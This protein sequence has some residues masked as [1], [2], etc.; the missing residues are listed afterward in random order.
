[1]WKRE[2]ETKTKTRPE[3]PNS[4]SPLPPSLPPPQEKFKNTL[5]EREDAFFRDLYQNPN[6]RKGHPL[7]HM[8]VSAA[9]LREHENS[10]SAYKKQ[11][12]SQFG[13]AEE[14]P[15]GGDQMVGEEEDQLASTA[16]TEGMPSF[17]SQSAHFQDLS[18][19]V[20]GG[21]G[22]GQKRM[23]PQARRAMRDA[24][25]AG[26]PSPYMR[27]QR[28]PPKR[29]EGGGSVAPRRL[30]PMSQTQAAKTK[31]RRKKKKNRGHISLSKSAS[32]PLV[33][34][35]TDSAKAHR[36]FLLKT[37]KDVR[38]QLE[39]PEP[40]PGAGE[41]GGAV[42]GAAAAA[43]GGAGGG[44]IRMGRRIPGIGA[45]AV[46][47]RYTPEGMYSFTVTDESSNRTYTT[48]VEV[49]VDEHF[50]GDYEGAARQLGKSLRLGDDGELEI[51]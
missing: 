27:V 23:T 24:M 9:E 42:S 30:T 40:L 14:M 26:A 35:A 29:G 51:M 50:Q 18:A 3:I 11:L 2:R 36:E 15:M 22:S 5:Q 44:H 6:L 21:Q 38:N 7:H 25:R 49:P 41:G 28:L 45:A 33:G 13:A 10:M 4:T 43:A 20:T 48:D 31:K 8:V 12:K 34:D 16:G 47:V 46:D 37:L 19:P 39:S 32:E 17:L 1:M